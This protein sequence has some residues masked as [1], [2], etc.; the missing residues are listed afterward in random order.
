MQKITPIISI[1]VLGLLLINL[2]LTVSISQNISRGAVKT[3]LAKA[4]EEINSDIVERF[5]FVAQGVIKNIDG[6][7]LTLVYL[8]ST[9]KVPVVVNA[10]IVKQLSNDALP[11]TISF[12]DLRVGDSVT[13][14]A[15]IQKDGS[16]GAYRVRIITRE[17]GQ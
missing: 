2:I 10:Q 1:A 15:E 9:L 3:E 8:E 17:A 11:E 13:A 14:L 6:S 12:Q 5:T 4:V 7:T 16:W